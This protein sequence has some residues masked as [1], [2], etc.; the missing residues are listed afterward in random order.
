MTRAPGKSEKRNRTKQNEAN[1]KQTT[2]I[3]IY[4]AMIKPLLS[5]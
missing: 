4:S 1:N 2:S 3:R 5:G